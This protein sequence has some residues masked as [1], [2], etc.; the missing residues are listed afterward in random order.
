MI[1]PHDAKLH[2][3]IQTM[4]AKPGYRLKFTFVAL[5]QQDRTIAQKLL[6]STDSDER[7][8][9]DAAIDVS[10][11][12]HKTSADIQNRHCDVKPYLDRDMTEATAAAHRLSNSTNPEIQR[13]AKC[14]LDQADAI[15]ESRKWFFAEMKRSSA[16]P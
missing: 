12:A 9:A 3:R 2:R 7:L 5:N 13:L 6:Q 4:E 15:A 16:S 11:I 14:V 10:D 1:D 8:L